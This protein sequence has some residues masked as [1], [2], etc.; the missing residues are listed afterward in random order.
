LTDLD[1][2][3]KRFICQGL[4]IRKIL[5]KKKNYPWGVFKTLFPLPLPYTPFFLLLI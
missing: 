1:K 3:G 4:S 5:E 2:A